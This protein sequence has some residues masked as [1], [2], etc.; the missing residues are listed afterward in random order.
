MLIGA[1]LKRAEHKR[2]DIVCA[3]RT[4]FLRE[5]YSDAG[6]EEVARAACV[7]TATLYA[8]FPSKADLFKRVVLE[9]VRDIA[10]PVGQSVNTQGDARTRLLAFANAYATFLARPLTRALFRLLTAERRRIEEIVHHVLQDARADLGGAAIQVVKDLVRTG[11]LT[12]EH[13]S[14][15]AG[16]LLGMIDH[17]TLILGLWAGDEARPRRPLQTICEEAVETFLAR[18]ATPATI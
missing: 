10:R 12:V 17:A 18:Y 9:T 13:P 2:S 15:A 1:G 3:A 5:G 16:Q 6:M 4:Q 8:H 14:W 7:S 11:E